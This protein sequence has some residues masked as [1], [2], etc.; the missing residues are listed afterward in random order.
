MLFL[1][2]KDYRT[3]TSGGKGSRNSGDTRPGAG[4]KTGNFVKRNAAGGYRRTTPIC[5]GTH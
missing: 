5:H 4:F 3:V 1:F 2:A